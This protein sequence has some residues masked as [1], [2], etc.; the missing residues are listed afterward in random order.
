MNPQIVH[1]CQ[2]IK[3]KSNLLNYNLNNSAPLILTSHFT[4]ERTYSEVIQTAQVYIQPQESWSEFPHNDSL[5][6]LSSTY[7]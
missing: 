2:N 5:A 3:M 6:H 1:N 4:P 7:P